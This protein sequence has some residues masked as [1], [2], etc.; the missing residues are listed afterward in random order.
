MQL[1]TPF[2]RMLVHQLRA[3]VDAILIGRHTDEREHPALTVRDW[4]GKNP[5]R[6]VLTHKLNIHQL[7]NELYTEGVQSLLVE[8]G[9]TTHQSFLN[10]GLWDEIRVETAPVVVTNGTKAAPLPKN[11]QI[12]NTKEYDGNLITSYIKTDGLQAK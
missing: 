2:T 5:R 8:G 7:M 3:D 4:S 9:A 10:A 11:I 1:S 12:A 6:I